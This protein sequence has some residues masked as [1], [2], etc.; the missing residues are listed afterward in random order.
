MSPL[1]DEF[2]SVYKHAR[3]K[4]HLHPSYIHLNDPINKPVIVLITCINVRYKKRI[5]E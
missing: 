5:N 1:V 3:S 4:F 2:T